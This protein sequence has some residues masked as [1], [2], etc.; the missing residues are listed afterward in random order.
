MAQGATALVTQINGSVPIDNQYEADFYEKLLRL[1]DDVLLGKHPYYKLPA[2]AIEQVVPRSIPSLAA[3]APRPTSNGSTNGVAAYNQPVTNGGTVISP[4]TSLRQNGT[5]HV[6]P[7]ASPF[8]HKP[9]T[10]QRLFVGKPPLTGIDPIFLTKSDTLA[11]AET[12]LKRQRLER[13]LSDQVAQRKNFSR[14][15][16]GVLEAASRLD[17]SMI[18]HA[19]WELVKPVSGLQPITGRQS[20]ASDSFDENSYYSSQANEWSSS[21]SAPNTGQSNAFRSLATQTQVTQRGGEDLAVSTLAEGHNGRP[22]DVLHHESDRQI[23]QLKAQP[24]TSLRPDGP[25]AHEEGPHFYA[26]EPEHRQELE[27]EESEYSPPAANAFRDSHG[28]EVVHDQTDTTGYRNVRAEV[29]MSAPYRQA[30]SP[31]HR[32]DHSLTAFPAMTV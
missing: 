5:T 13:A 16:D 11:R 6:F 15:K 4:D 25:P 9:P 31:Q 19:A 17:L 21:E 3:S 30:G 8:V 20:G 27:R 22:A 2:T 28:N 29:D 24:F 23:E 1:Q 32:P 14:E 12:Q 7:P 18:L 26:Q 10:T